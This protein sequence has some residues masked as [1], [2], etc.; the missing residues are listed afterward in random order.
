MFELDH[1]LLNLVLHGLMSSRIRRSKSFMMY[2]LLTR[3]IALECCVHS[4]R[5]ARR[6][7]H[8]G[9]IVTDHRVALPLPAQLVSCP[10]NA[11]PFLNRLNSLPRMPAAFTRARG[12]GLNSAG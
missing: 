2:L 8:N 12:R 10:P 7:W 5:L 3:Y 9:R 6:T 11:R 1:Q 4:G